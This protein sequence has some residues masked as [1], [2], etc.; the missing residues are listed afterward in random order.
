VTPIKKSGQRCLATPIVSLFNC[1]PED[2]QRDG[3]IP[4]FQKFNLAVKRQ[5]FPSPA[6]TG[7]KTLD[8][9][10]AAIGARV[11][12]DLRWLKDNRL[13][14][15]G[16]ADEFGREERERAAANSISWFPAAIRELAAKISELG[17]C[18]YLATIDEHDTKIGTWDFRPI[19]QAWREGSGPPISH[20]TL[21]PPG[22]L[23]HPDTAELHNRQIYWFTCWTLRDYIRQI[24]RAL[25]GVRKDWLL[26]CNICTMG[27]KYVVGHDGQILPSHKGVEPQWIVAEGWAALAMG[28]SYLECYSYNPYRWRQ[29]FREQ[30]PNTTLWQGMCPGLGRPGELWGGFGQLLRTIKDHEHGLMMSPYEPVFNGPW[31]IGRRG[32]FVWAINRSRHL[33][34]PPWG[35]ANPKAESG[36][37]LFRYL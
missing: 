25:S 23:E 4:T 19:V 8:E 17:N 28:A 24:K 27:P 29:A 21:N 18:R 20:P 11:L 36:T 14:L 22:R 33:Q 3:L 13:S 32:Q 1:D 15:I 16:E 7:A 6:Y 34:R 26:S 35:P 37:V 12:P 30:K 2:I 5:I 10:R 9:H 31:V